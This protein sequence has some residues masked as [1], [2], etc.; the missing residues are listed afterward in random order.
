M[1]YDKYQHQGLQLADI[2]FYKY[3]CQI[4]VIKVQHARTSDLRFDKEYLNY[5]TLCQQVARQHKD[6]ITLLIYSK[7]RDL[8]NKQDAILR[9]FK[10][11]RPIRKYYSRGLTG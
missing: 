2:C 4:L 9:E 11:K 3:C 7:I 10:N 1:L 8:D 6:L 5:D